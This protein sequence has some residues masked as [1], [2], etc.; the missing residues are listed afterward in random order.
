MQIPHDTIACSC[1]YRPKQDMNFSFIVNDFFIYGVISGSPVYTLNRREYEIVTTWN[2]ASI[3]Y[4]TIT[5]FRQYIHV[6][7][8]KSLFRWKTNGTSTYTGKGLKSDLCFFQRNLVL[9]SSEMSVV[10][11]VGGLKCHVFVQVSK[12]KCHLYLPKSSQDFVELYWVRRFHVFLK[13]QNHVL[14][15]LRYRIVQR[16][17]FSFSL[18]YLQP[19][20][21]TI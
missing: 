14:R 21:I 15:L 17:I 11:N 3:Q 19:S 10:W 1:E 16:S 8:C 6:R 12:G 20:F 18:K 4:L 2:V 13:F 5:R 7:I 9:I